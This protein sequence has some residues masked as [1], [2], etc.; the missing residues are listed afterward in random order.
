[1]AKTKSPKRQQNLLKYFAVS[2]QEERLQLSQ[3]L[4]EASSSTSSNQPSKVQ[5]KTEVP[6]SRK[7]VPV[8][9]ESDEE[10]VDQGDDTMEEVI[11]RRRKKLRLI[12]ESSDEESVEAPVNLVSEGAASDQDEDMDDDLDFL[13]TS[14]ILQK[15]TRGKRVDKYAE[16]LKRLK[17]RKSRSALYDT[18]E[19]GPIESFVTSKHRPVIVPSSG[20]EDDNDEEGD[21]DDDDDFVVDDDI[22]DGKKVDKPVVKTSLPAEFSAQKSMSFRRQMD[23]Y[24]QSLIELVLDPAFDIPS[25]DKYAVANETIKRRVQAYRD[26]MTTSDVWLPEFKSDLDKYTNWARFQ[27]YVYDGTILCGACRANKPASRKI[28]LFS[29]DILDSETYYLGSECSKKAFMYHALKHFR[30]HMYQKVR[31]LVNDKRYNA[32]TAQEVFD[33]LLQTGQVR[34][35]RRNITNLLS[36]VV[37]K[38]NPRGQR[39]GVVEDDSDS[40]DD[41][42]DDGSDSRAYGEDMY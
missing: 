15:R 2:S 21:S 40:S 20:S 28:H 31:N 16:N 1:M 24:I 30:T 14:D 18:V 13:D 17:D 29:D 19:D 23:F 25:N 11:P 10:D 38:Y 37:V 8:I 9:F 42:F 35:L 33:N 39:T 27:G 34:K 26:S 32:D 3:D 7:K 4:P 36:N 5:K 12:V 22:V 41:D 6:H